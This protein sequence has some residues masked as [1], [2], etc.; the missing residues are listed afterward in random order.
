MLTFSAGTNSSVVRIAD[1]QA[2]QF[3]RL[4]DAQVYHNGL[5]CL[6]D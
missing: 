4:E 2:I 6:A 5:L 1:W 3:D